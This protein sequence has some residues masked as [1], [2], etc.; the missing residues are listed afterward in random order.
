MHNV[1]VCHCTQQLDR[2]RPIPFP[3]PFGD[4]GWG[5]D[6]VMAN[7]NNGI[8]FCGNA[9]RIC[10]W[11]FQIWRYILVSLLLTNSIIQALEILQGYLE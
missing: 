5:N 1:H 6:M 4:E 10:R 8:L 2:F 3:T 7:Y 9:E 11:A